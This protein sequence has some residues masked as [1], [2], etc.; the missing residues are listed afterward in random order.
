M[1]N[2]LSARVAAFARVLLQLVVQLELVSMESDELRGDDSWLE[3]EL[4]YSSIGSS[5]IVSMQQSDGRSGSRSATAAG[6]EASPES[7][8]EQSFEA[9]WLRCSCRESRSNARNSWQSCW[10]G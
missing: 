10:V 1:G 6:S 9:V 8:D 2:D 7:F 3:R 4:S 5:F